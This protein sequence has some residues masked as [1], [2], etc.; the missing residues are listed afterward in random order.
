MPSTDR[1]KR[2]VASAARADEELIAVLSQ[3]ALQNGPITASAVARQMASVKHVSAL[4]RDRWRMEQIR[5]VENDRSR[6][7]REHLMSCDAK[8]GD[9]GSGIRLALDSRE[10]RR[11]KFFLVIADARHLGRAAS[12][13]GLTPSGLSQHLAAFEQ[14]IGGKLFTR[15]SHGVSPTYLGAQLRR[16]LEI[17]TPI[18]TAPLIG[19]YAGPHGSHELRIGVPSEYCALLAPQIISELSQAKIGREIDVAELSS[20]DIEEALIDHSIDI[21]FIPNASNSAELWVE[22]TAREELGLVSAPA[23]AEA[24]ESGSLRLRELAGSSIIL[25]SQR[26]P[27]SR[28]LAKA[29]SEHNLR[30]N[31]VYQTDSFVL[32]KE[33][34]RRWHSSTILPRASVR[35]ELARGTL[36][37]RSITAPHVSTTIAVARNLHP[38]RSIGSDLLDALHA[39]IERLSRDGEWP[40]AVRLQA[41]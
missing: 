21:G 41:G 14:E 37:Y 19:P 1:P 39:S 10:L 40:G 3:M 5:R 16:R 38:T 9:I 25:P 34:V 32:R 13:L 26:H 2:N 6:I 15:H 35:E 22:P 11:F 33:L 8:G 20:S 31:P 24:V 4:T 28:A 12:Q 36:V 27:I 23:S 29:C 18:L 7:R 30:L 17:V